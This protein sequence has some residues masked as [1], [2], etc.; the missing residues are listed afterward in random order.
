MLVYKDLLTNFLL[1]NSA[2]LETQKHEVLFVFPLFLSEPLGFKTYIN[3][4]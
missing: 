3:G 2:H 4:V 1:A